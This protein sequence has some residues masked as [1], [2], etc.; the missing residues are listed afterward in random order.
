MQA[1]VTYESGKK[2]GDLPPELHR[3][4]KALARG[5]NFKAL[6][7]A[8]M[9]SPNLKEAIKGRICSDISKECKRLCSK[10][11]PSLLRGMTKEAMVNFSWQAVGKELQTKA[12]LFLR[13]ILAAADPANGTA[14]TYDAVRHPGVYTAAAILLKKRDKAISLIPYVISTILKVGKT[15][16]MVR[17]KTKPVLIQFQNIFCN[18][19]CELRKRLVFVG[20]T[21]FDPT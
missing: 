16:K 11:D 13:C 18:Q 14:T 1:V 5:S 9:E 21:N 6:A 7:D 3:L 10:A 17:S 20:I 15:S 12:P 2:S 19:Y 8:A 4:G